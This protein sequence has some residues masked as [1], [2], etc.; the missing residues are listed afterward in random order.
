MHVFYFYRLKGFVVTCMQ[1]TCDGKN[2]CSKNVC[3]LNNLQPSG[4]PYTTCARQNNR[5]NSLTIC[6][7]VVYVLYGWE[8]LFT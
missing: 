5:V 3:S 4:L 7:Y 1:P 2:V 6:H 8:H